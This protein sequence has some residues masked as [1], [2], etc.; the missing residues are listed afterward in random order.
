MRHGGIIAAAIEVLQDIETRH[1]PATLALK[2]WGLSHRFAGSGDRT[3]IG[4]LVFDALRHRSSISWRMGSDQARALAIGAHRFVWG[5]EVDEIE[6]LFTSDPHAPAALSEEE[7]ARLEIGDLAG[8]PPAVMGDYPAWLDRELR[9][10]FGDDLVPQMAALAA[11]APID[12]RVNTLKADRAKVIKALGRL[13]VE[14]TPHSPVGL[15]IAAGEGAARAPNV[16]ADMSFKKGWFEIQDEGSQLAALLTGATAGEQVADICAGG[17]G[18]TLAMAAAMQG[19]GQVHAWDADRNRLGDIHERVQRAAAR[20]VQIIGGGDA[21]LLAPLEGRMDLV[22]VDAPCSGTGT[23]RRRP[24][25]KWRLTEK[26]LDDRRRDQREALA[27]LAAPL[28]RPGGRIAYVTCSVLP[29]ENDGA[30]EAFLEGHPGF[31]VRADLLER[32]PALNGVAL[33]ARHGLLLTP[34]VAG[35]D[36][37]YVSVLERR[38]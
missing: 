23:W 26:S 5:S 10:V 35:T 3:A 37:F 36:G 27:A 4:N 24:D 33:P 28:V 16:Q 9:D 8:A 1:R 13:P 2:D 7:R 6:R 30:I 11:R 31:G 21:A 32:L 14:E 19:K 18:K 12:L 38:A 20:N 29:S 22:L 25:A 17:G 34:L 15:R